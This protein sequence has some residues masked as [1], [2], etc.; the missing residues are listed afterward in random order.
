MSSVVLPTDMKFVYNI[1][2]V[3]QGSDAPAMFDEDSEENKENWVVY[4]V[5]TVDIKQQYQER[6][7]IVISILIIEVK[8]VHVILVRAKI[9]LHFIGSWIL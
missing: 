3:I 4:K 5:P 1:L 2:G 9:P 7:L 6:N 8:T